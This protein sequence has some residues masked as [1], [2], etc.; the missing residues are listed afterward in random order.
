MLTILKHSFQHINYN[1]K[2][3]NF[4]HCTKRI[5]CFISYK[6]HQMRFQMISFFL[7]F[8]NIIYVRAVFFTQAKNVG[9]R[10]YMK[11]RVNVAGGFCR[12][13]ATNYEPPRANT[14][15]KI[16]LF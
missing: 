13:L 2:P 8:I 11:L 6:N 15:L 7:S 1:D 4:F 16:I 14:R 12:V 9:R 10:I 5:S 3:G